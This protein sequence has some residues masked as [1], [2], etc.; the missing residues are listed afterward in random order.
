MAFSATTSRT[1][2]FNARIDVASISEGAGNLAR[3]FA[4]SWPSSTTTFAGSCLHRRALGDQRSPSRRF[5]RTAVGSLLQTD[6]ES[7]GRRHLGPLRCLGVNDPAEAM[8]KPS[9]AG[10][11]KPAKAR[12]RQPSRLK[13]HIP[14]KAVA[15]RNAATDR[16]AEWL[17]KLDL[18]Q[19]AP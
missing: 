9:R 8:K 7:H 18:G 10:S 13:R 2:S 14:P 6:S 1:P 17:E 15:H 19:Y 12:P 5:C 3:S 4:S 11:G 16:I